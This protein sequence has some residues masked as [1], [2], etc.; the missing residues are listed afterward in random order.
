MD[1]NYY[2]NVLI[3]IFIFL[4]VGNSFDQPLFSSDY[5]CLNSLLKRLNKLNDPSIQPFWDSGSQ[6][7]DFCKLYS[8]STGIGKE[9]LVQYYLQS[10]SLKNVTSTPYTMPDISYSDFQCF[11]RLNS[12]ELIGHKVNSDIFM[13]TI[14]KSLVSSLSLLNCSNVNIPT[15]IQPNITSLIIELSEPLVNSGG[16]ISQSILINLKTFIIKTTIQTSTSGYSSF[17]YPF[18]TKDAPSITLQMD[19]FVFITATIPDLSKYTITNVEITVPQIV[20]ISKLNTFIKVKNL[21]IDFPNNPIDFPTLFTSTDNILETLILKSSINSPA[22]LIDFT[23]SKSLKSFT[24]IQRA[25]P[26]TPFTFGTTGSFPFSTLPVSLEEINF[27]NAGISTFGNGSIFVN[28]KKINFASNKITGTLPSAIPSF[29]S[30]SLKG[31]YYFGSI[32]NKTYCN[33]ILDVSENIKIEGELPQCFSCYLPTQPSVFKLFNRTQIKLD[34]IKQENCTLKAIPNLTIIEKKKFQLSGENLGYEIPF[35]YSDAQL[36]N[37]QMV[38]PNK[39]FTGTLLRELED[40]IVFTFMG[41]NYT[42]QTKS[43]EPNY[44]TVYGSSR[45]STQN[46]FQFFG[47]YFTYNESQVS[48]TVNGYTCKVIS[49]AFETIQCDT[50]NENGAPVVLSTDKSYFVCY[51]SISNYT[52]QLTLSS[53]SKVSL[54]NVCTNIC[55]NGGICNTLVGACVCPSTWTGSDCTIKDLDCPSNCTYPNGVCNRLTGICS[56]TPKWNASD[57]SNSVPT[58]CLDSCV[59]GVCNINNN[60]CQCL[61]NWTGIDCTTKDLDCPSN[62]NYPNGV[63]DRLTG[64][65]SCTTKGDTIDCSIPVPTCPVTCNNGICNANTKQCECLPT[66]TG[67]D[68]TTRDFDCPNNCTYPNGNCNR[69]TGECGCTS[70]WNSSD[71]SN[72]VPTCPDTCNNGICNDNTKK[73]ECRPTWTGIDCTTRDFDCPNNCTYPNGDCNRLNGVC[74]CKSDWQ[75]QD[76][77]NPFKKCIGGCNEIESGSKCNN[78]TGECSCTS[79]YTGSNCLVA[80]QYISSIEP[81]TTDGGLVKMWGWF[82]KNRTDDLSIQIGSLVCSV[83]LVNSSYIEC[84]IGPDSGTKSVTIVQNGLKYT[85][86][87]IYHY[88]EITYKCPNDCSGHGTCNKLVGQCKCSSGWGGFDCNAKSTTGPTTSTSSSTTTSSPSPSTTSQTQQ[89]TSTPEQIIIPDTITKVNKTEGSALIN[90][91]KTTY[92]IKII[93][94]VELNYDQSIVKTSPLNNR[95]NVDTS[96]ENKFTFNQTLNNTNCE[97][98]YSIEELKETRDYSFAGLDLTLDKGSIK[99]S[100][101][102][103]NYPYLN[104]LNTLQ[105]QMESKIGE[106]SN[107]NENNNNECNKE[108][109]QI[110]TNQLDKNQVLNYVTISKDQ[111]ILYGRFINRV[112]SDSKPTFITT[113]IIQ[114]NQSDS[115]ILGVNLPHCKQSCLIDPD[116]SV[117]VSSN[118]R[119]CSNEDNENNGRASWVLPVAIVVPCVAVAAI[120]IIGSI[121]YRKNRTSILLAKEKYSFNLKK[122]SKKSNSDFYMPD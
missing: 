60:K 21:I 92:E 105:L 34:S 6:S 56:C 15:T 9:G 12:I 35:S 54:V 20:D 99:I 11:D 13:P 90:N 47:K 50:V 86:N 118:Y 84:E 27:E 72:P 17:M 66:W 95:W 4:S 100:V 91:E 81:T 32:P 57:C 53:T 14:T 73:C 85:G 87:D 103:K 44:T 16:L 2:F 36:T 110:N 68:C 55:N 70:K 97:I 59:N 77:I 31:N 76:C 8:C 104:S 49:T 39:L 94:L 65:C 96:I 108:N 33:M 117:L 61:T 122:Y 71:C 43:I 42:L 116:F 88:T 26:P 69:L 93:S 30:L 29:L 121:V 120:L 10:I 102:I 113:S 51:I 109:T 58:S 25:N 79:D 28:L 1:N 18:F 19:T 5:N 22:V 7:Y 67:I 52:N 107:S 23:R 64:V 119:Q 101:E 37:K 82:G 40:V 80:S 111:K 78:I 112:V 3:F 83:T 24:F 98:I 46:T 74:T 106:T 38:I 75:S 62:C 41:S 114:T 63:C 45:G 48:I 115:I 89:P